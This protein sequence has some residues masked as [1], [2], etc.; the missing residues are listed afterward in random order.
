[1]EMGARLVRQDAPL[2]TM[3]APMKSLVHCENTLLLGRLP[4]E[5]YAYMM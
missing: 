4:L 2:M 5:A 1:M 3:M